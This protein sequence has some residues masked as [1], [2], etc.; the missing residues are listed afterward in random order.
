MCSLVPID[1]DSTAL[2]I[3]HRHLTTPY[4][5]KYDINDALYWTPFIFKHHYLNVEMPYQSELKWR[6]ELNNWCEM[7]IEYENIPD[8]CTLLKWSEPHINYLVNLQETLSQLYFQNDNVND[9][10][11]DHF[12]IEV[13]PKW[14]SFHVQMKHAINFMMWLKWNQLM[15]EIKL[16]FEQ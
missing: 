7:N 11:V 1:V 3:K 8:F 14:Q 9:N 13:E 10:E 15:K 2:N 12:Q 16:H 5:I 4:H 6:V